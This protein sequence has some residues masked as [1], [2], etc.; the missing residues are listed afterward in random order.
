MSAL[1]PFTE[2]ERAY[3]EENHGLVFSFFNRK[4]FDETE[5]YDV[6]VFGY[7][8]TVQEYIRNPGRIRC[9]STIAYYRMQQMVAEE[10]KY[11]SREKRSGATVSLDA[12]IAGTDGIPVIETL[13]DPQSDICGRIEAEE[14]YSTI[15]R[16][17]TPR[18][19]QLL[20]YFAAGISRPSEIFPMLNISRDAVAN[21]IKKIR[22]KARPLIKEQFGIT[23]AEVGLKKRGRH[24][25]RYEREDE[26]ERSRSCTKKKPPKNEGSVGAQIK[27]RYT[28]ILTKGESRV[29]QN[30]QT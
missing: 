11:Q 12:V 15:M 6:V 28:Y 23:D 7:L 16:I 2:A 24:R 4:G 3:A 29:N 8:N 22:M 20:P 21:R 30:H 18:E 14:I 26:V 27:N 17:A 9:F 25:K 10:I 1:K 13:A 19:S 5:W